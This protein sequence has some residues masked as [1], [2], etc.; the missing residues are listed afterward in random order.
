M[1]IGIDAHGLGGH[2]LGAGNEQYTRQ[3]ILNLLQ[4][5]RGNEYHLFVHEPDELRHLVADHPNAKLVAL[6]PRSQWVQ[7]P[8]SAPWYAWR[9]GLDVLHVPFIR[10]P[11]THTRTVITVHDTLFET[12]PEYY[13]LLERTRMKALVPW[14]CRRADLIFTVSEFSR[15]QIHQHYGVDPLRI[16]VTPN[17]ADHVDHQAANAA[18]HDADLPERYICFIGTL[19]PRKNLARLVRA[20]DELLARR[21]LPHHLLLVG[22][23]GWNNGE[24]MSALASARHRRRIHLTG[25]V[26]ES[27]MR[28]ILLRSELLVCPSIAEGFAVP[29]L[30]A[31]RACI[32]VVV[33]R[34]TCFP[35]IYGDSAEYCDPLEESSIVDAIETALCSPKRRL[36]LMEAGLRNSQRFSWRRTAEAAL[37]AYR[38][39][40]LGD[41]AAPPEE[42]AMAKGVRR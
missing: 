14:S 40:A 4:I 20:F 5:D 27:R 9:H 19:Q 2:S 32:P 41:L 36:E 25:F 11:F 26:T 1:R 29:P 38:A 18:L 6:M 39:L 22:R 31:Q 3:L 23:P 10:P 12:V 13:T 28:S 33:S 15:R 30:E 7:R 42:V 8:V 21:A 17:A 37:R 24:L 34:T 35:E 16:V